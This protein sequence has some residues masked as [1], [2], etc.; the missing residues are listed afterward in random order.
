MCPAPP[1]NMTQATDI[2]T[3]ITAEDVNRILEAGRRR[4]ASQQP[5]V[6]IPAPVQE[7]V[8]D[9]D[10]ELNRNM[11]FV[12]IAQALCGSMPACLLSRTKLASRF[13][14]L[15]QALFQPYGGITKLP[16]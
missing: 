6:Q 7:Q 16:E 11:Q 15:A 5:P 9:S 10:V 14:L 4:R 12:P 1:N 3:T 8:Q 2:V 13:I